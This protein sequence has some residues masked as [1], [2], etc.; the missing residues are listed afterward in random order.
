MKQVINAARIMR[1]INVSL[2]LLTT[3]E[4]CGLR[5]HVSTRDNVGRVF[6]TGTKAFACGLVQRRERTGND[7]WGPLSGRFSGFRPPATD[8]QKLP[9][10]PTA[11]YDL[12]A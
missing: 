3:Q 9:E 5:P 6:V 11:P 1:R 7:E 10:G 4:P 2:I 8:F 12:S